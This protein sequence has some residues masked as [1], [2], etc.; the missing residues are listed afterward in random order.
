MEHE[1]R[2]KFGHDL[3]FTTRNYGITTTPD[4][5]WAV[6]VENAPAENTEHGRRVKPVD[7]CMALPLVRDAELNRAEV[8]AVML[9]TGPMVSAHSR[10]PIVPASQ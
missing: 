1:H 9:Y 7:E 8:V 2:S 10:A 6:V 4:R 5:E 3:P